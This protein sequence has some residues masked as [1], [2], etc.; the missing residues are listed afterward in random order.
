[1]KSLTPTERRDKAVFISTSA[2]VAIS[3]LF[4]SYLFAVQH[5]LQRMQ[6]IFY[7]D[8][9]SVSVASTACR[10]TVNTIA[11][12][13]D[14]QCVADEAVVGTISKILGNISVFETITYFLIVLC[15]I[16]LVYVGLSALLD[17]LMNRRKSSLDKLPEQR[18]RILNEDLSDPVGLC[19]V[20]DQRILQAKNKSNKSDI[21]ALDYLY[22][23]RTGIIKPRTKSAYQKAFLES[24]IGNSQFSDKVNEIE[25]ILD[26]ERLPDAL[27]YRGKYSDLKGVFN[28]FAV[29]RKNSSP[30]CIGNSSED[31]RK[32]E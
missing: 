10:D 26:N 2:V 22:L 21:L 23:S 25:G 17:F 7:A 5:R 30:T 32:S 9:D 1:M 12:T 27:D 3:V 31:D 18:A 20:I 14:V 4:L 19:K 11:E 13:T 16:I 6:A 15:V 24:F 8:K 28:R 29:I